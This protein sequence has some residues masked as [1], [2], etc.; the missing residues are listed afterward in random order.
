VGVGNTFSIR[1][2]FWQNSC[3]IINILMTGQGGNQD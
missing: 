3:S 2:S 1:T